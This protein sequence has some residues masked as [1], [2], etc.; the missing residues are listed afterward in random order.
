MEIIE[1]KKEQDMGLTTAE[2]INGLREAF[3]Q[4]GNMM[5]AMSET[6]AKQNDR[7]ASM[8]RK[9]SA[10]EKVTPAQAGELGRRITARADE[11]AESY[12][13]SGGEKQLAAAIRRAVKVET[14]VS[15]LKSISRCDWKIVLELIGSWDD[16]SV[17]REI[18]KQIREGKI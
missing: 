17:V 12:R 13:I 10:L 4:M 1:M 8:E 15:S 7:L 6:I 9:I 2:A 5:Q 3:V 18:K 14:G 16:Y 11:L